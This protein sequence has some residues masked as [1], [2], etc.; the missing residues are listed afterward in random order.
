MFDL[1]G[2]TASRPPADRSLEHDDVDVRRCG[3]DAE[4]FLHELGALRAEANGGI[5]GVSDACARD[6]RKLAKRGLRPFRQVRHFE[7]CRSD[8]VGREDGVAAANAHDGNT[9]SGEARQVVEGDGA[10]VEL[11]DAVNAD[12][13]GLA[14]GG[15]EDLCLAGEAA[16]V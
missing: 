3:D 10:I 5:D 13:A 11:L 2:R 14:A 8:V 9:W 7:A 6:G 4:R 15:V 1:I 16:G 12:G